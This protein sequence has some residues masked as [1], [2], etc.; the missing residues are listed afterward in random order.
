MV[1]VKT[2]S[3]DVS[4]QFIIGSGYLD[5]FPEKKDSSGVTDLIRVLKGESQF[6]GA[7]GRI[8]TKLEKSLN[9]L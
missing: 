8:D 7:D 1:D 5:I 2:N 3:C 9:E 6:R 4:R